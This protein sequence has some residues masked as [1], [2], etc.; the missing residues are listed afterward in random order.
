[1]K[2]SPSMLAAFLPTKNALWSSLN[3]TALSKSSQGTPVP[4]KWHPGL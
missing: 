1:M 2:H 3:P 4:S